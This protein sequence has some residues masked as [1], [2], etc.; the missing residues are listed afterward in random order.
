MLF[1]KIWRFLKNPREKR[2]K[3][4]TDFYKERELRT[5]GK[6]WLE[7]ERKEEKNSQCK[8]VEFLIFSF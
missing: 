2:E 5:E 6:F 1:E 3:E 4:L 8:K 7:E